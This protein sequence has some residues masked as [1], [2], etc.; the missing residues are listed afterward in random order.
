MSFLHQQAPPN[1]K[2]GL[3]RGLVKST[4][5]PRIRSLQSQD[6]SSHDAESD[7]NKEPE[8]YAVYE[9]AEKRRQKLLKKNHK[10]SRNTDLLLS[11]YRNRSLN[12]NAASKITDIDELNKWDL[13]P[14][15]NTTRRKHIQVQRSYTIP[16]AT[17]RNAGRLANSN[18][19]LILENTKAIM[20]SDECAAL[21]YALAEL[22]TVE[23]ENVEEYLSILNLFSTTK[24]GAMVDKILKK[25]PK[26]SELWKVKINLCDDEAKKLDLVHRA[27]YIIP[28]DKGLWDLAL[29][30]D[31]TYR[32]DVR[33]LM[34]KYATLYPEINNSDDAADVMKS[35]VTEMVSPKEEEKKKEEEVSKPTTIK[36]PSAEVAE[37]SNTTVSD[38]EFPLTLENIDKLNP[39]QRHTVYQRLADAQKSKVRKRAIYTKALTKFPDDT[40]LRR[41]YESI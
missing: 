16:D 29:D 37:L 27:L 19:L 30:L 2:A 39:S 6:R 15:S 40:E 8:E 13:K 1:Y 11:K 12:D 4:P 35:S 17:I 22:D 5:H 34:S 23:F 25:V 20:E 14:P 31:P 18:P 3:G 41:L 24:Q 28:N 9:L 7:T 36:I 10:I 38:Q 26:S 21:E 32:S 33:E